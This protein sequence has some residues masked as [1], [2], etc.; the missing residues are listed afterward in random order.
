MHTFI[1]EGCKVKKEILFKYTLMKRG[2]IM[3]KL[4]RK[5]I[6]FGIS[7]LM[8]VG[9]V[10]FNTVFAYAMYSFNGAA[11]FTWNNVSSARTPSRT[12]V[13]VFWEGSDKPSH[14]MWFGLYNNSTQRA[15]SL[16]N[17]LGT[18]NFPAGS[19]GRNNQ[20]HLRARREN[21]IDPR[22]YINGRW[23]P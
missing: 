8:F 6:V 22:T 7:V 3:K 13:V 2:S 1:I 5:V 12:P 23:Q 21:I 19:A 18:V 9:F 20:I 15:T 10:N 11:S 17:Y 4:R 14:R 16:V